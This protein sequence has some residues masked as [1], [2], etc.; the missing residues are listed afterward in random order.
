MAVGVIAATVAVVAAA[1]KPDD[2]LK[3]MIVEGMELAAAEE[4]WR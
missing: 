4:R 1:I 2:A 3:K